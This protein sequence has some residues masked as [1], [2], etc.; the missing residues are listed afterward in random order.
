M[1]IFAGVMARDGAPLDTE[2]RRSLH[3]SLSRHPAD[4]PT[5]FEG[6]GWTCAVIDIGAFDAPT[7]VGLPIGTVSRVGPDWFE[8]EAI[9]PLSNGDGLT[10][11]NKREVVGV[12][13]DT[14]TQTGHA[15]RVKPN[16]PIAQLPGLKVGTQ[17]SRNRDHAR[18]PGADRRG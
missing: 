15:W 11:M 14:V 10:W 1:S 3:A 4:T 5:V 7:H 8:L 6:P 13:A 12:Q 16:Q 9:E 17:V 2:T 18:H